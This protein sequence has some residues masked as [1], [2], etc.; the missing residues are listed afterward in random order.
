MLEFFS[1]S[2]FAGLLGLG[3][4]V[5]SRKLRVEKDKTVEDLLTVLPGLNCGACG[6]A[7]CEGYAE[8]LAAEKDSNI[9]KCSPGGAK[10]LGGIG[11]IL[12]KEVDSSKVRMVA[13]LA[14]AGGDGIAKR[15]FQYLG[16][17]DCEAAAV[18]FGGEKGC[19]YGCMG[20]G[21]CVKS[22]PVE[23][24]SYTDNGLVRVDPDKCIGCEICV[25]VCPTSA[26]KMVPE[27]LPW[28]VACNS[29]DKAKD[30]KKACTVGCIGCRICAK[31]F[32]E[33][34]F[35]ITDNLSLLDYNVHN[36]EQQAGAAGACPSKCIIEVKTS[37]KY[38]QTE[39][40]C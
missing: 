31:K 34:G 35:V 32:P 5:A 3:L 19:K 30:T 17:S 40:E 28:F 23:A 6:Y 36:E 7:G 25:T 29:K 39:Q 4:A 15:D 38:K 1:T 37:D 27:D 22:C 8:A 20:L 26:M 10:A 14:C 11:E 21:S 18:H 24:I 33:S 2:L 9:S 13:R 12:G 16:Y